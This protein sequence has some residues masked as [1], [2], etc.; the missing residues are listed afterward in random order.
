MTDREE[1]IEF[2]LL[3]EEEFFIKLVDLYGDMVKRVAFTYVRDMKMAE[4]IVQDVFIKCYNNIATFQGKSSY[5]T[6]IY[7]ITI[8]HCKDVMRKRFFLN[9]HPFKEEQLLPTF[10]TPESILLKKD[11]HTL[12]TK[13]LLELPKKYR[14]VLYLY[15]YEELKI[16]EISEVTQLNA[17]TV[18]T[19]L[20]RGKLL[21][22]AEIERRDGHL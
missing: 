11:N 13:T 2:N 22:K 6:W 1:A 17:E 19:R 7:R 9:F 21:L 15:Y 4:D 14:E 16:T 12:V 18:K 5:K 10:E 8:N 20:R 3:S